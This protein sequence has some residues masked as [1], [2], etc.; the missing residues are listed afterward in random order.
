MNYRMKILLPLLLISLLLLP[1]SSLIR[2]SPNSVQNNAQPLQVL[3]DLPLNIFGNDEL[4]DAANGGGNGQPGTPYIIKDKIINA[5]GIGTD[6]IRIRNTNA[7]FILKNCTVT[8]AASLYAG[9]NLWNVTHARLEN[10]ILLNNFWGIELWFSYNNTV[11]GNTAYD[12]AAGIVV[13]SS[14]YTT[15][16]GNTA[17]NNSYGIELLAVSCK[18]TLADNTVYNNTN[19]GIL[20]AYSQHNTL[21]GNPASFS[22]YGF[23]VS[24]GH[25]NTLIGNSAYNN[26]DGIQ[27]EYSNYTTL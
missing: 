8:N 6:G 5:S 18:N 15:V 26:T 10:N 16:T 22:P 3:A 25:N 2:S 1:W 12:N 21:T 13:Y 14:N 23:R 24:F 19:T 20:V 7:Y 9:I 11:T 27:V 4:E 17:N